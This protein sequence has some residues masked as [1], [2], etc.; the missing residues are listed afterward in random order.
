LC[1]FISQPKVLAFGASTTCV[2]DL[3]VRAS[4]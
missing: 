1:S 4:S 2:L 3:P